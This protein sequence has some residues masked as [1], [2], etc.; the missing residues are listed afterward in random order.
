MKIDD[1]VNDDIAIGKC[2]KKHLG[3]DIN[4]NDAMNVSANKKIS[5]TLRPA[6]M[7]YAGLE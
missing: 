6:S 5:I 3:T 7:R 4:A 1:D 2:T